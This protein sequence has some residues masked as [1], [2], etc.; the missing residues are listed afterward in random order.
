MKSKKK[1]KFGKEWEEGCLMARFWCEPD[2]E[3]EDWK[4]EMKSVRKLS[5][6]YGEYFYT[7]VYD[8]FRGRLI[9]FD[10]DKPDSMN[11]ARALFNS[12][13]QLAMCDVGC[14][15]RICSDVDG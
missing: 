5:K 3:D 1:S 12:L 11:E 6:E 14:G 9:W 10:D 15:S 8:P 4:V 13:V 2:G 7:V